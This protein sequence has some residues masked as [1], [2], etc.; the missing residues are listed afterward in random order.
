MQTE[1]SLWSRDIE[2]EVVPTCRRLGIGVVAYA[3]LGRGLLTGTINSQ[4]SLPPQDLRRSFA[5]FSERNFAHNQRI[6]ATH[7]ACRT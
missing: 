3:P 5:R 7:R 1:W 4:D 2:D 6:A